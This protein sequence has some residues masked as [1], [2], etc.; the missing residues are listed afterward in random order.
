MAGGAIYTY[1]GWTVTI[2]HRGVL[3]VTIDVVGE[4]VHTGSSDWSRRR[5]GHNAVAALCAIVCRLEEEAWPRDEHP[6]FPFLPVTVTPGTLISGGS[7]ESVVP[8]SASCA[9]DVRLPPEHSPWEMLEPD[10]RALARQFNLDSI[11]L[12]GEGPPLKDRVLAHI[13]QTVADVV[14]ARRGR[15]PPPLAASVTVTVDIPPYVLPEGKDHPLAQACAA[16]VERATGAPPPEVRGAGPANEGWML[17]TAGIP[18]IC[19]LGPRGWGFHAANEGVEVGESFSQTMDVYE[20]VVM[21][22]LADAQSQVA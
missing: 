11:R 2:G 18:V 16:A 12:A 8:A 4:S 17:H 5:R 13:R 10:E 15:G 9:V 1:P 14:A 21:A 20:Q 19:G 7:C 6:A 3:R 22:A